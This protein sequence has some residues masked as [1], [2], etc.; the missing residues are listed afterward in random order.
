MTTDQDQPFIPLGR[1][2]S[3]KLHYYVRHAEF[4]MILPPSRHTRN[5]LIFLAPLSYWEKHA[6]NNRDGICWMAAV[7]HCFN[8]TGN[9]VFKPDKAKGLE[10]KQ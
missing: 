2:S 7:Q 9:K 8:L 4:Q 10:P 1:D 3:G 5:N 6:G